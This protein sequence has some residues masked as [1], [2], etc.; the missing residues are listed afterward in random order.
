VKDIAERLRDLA[1]PRKASMMLGSRTM[2]DAADEIERLREVV[3][4]ADPGGQV[5]AKLDH[6]KADRKRSSHG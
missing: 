2:L 3:R 4:L 1:G 5:R 6:E